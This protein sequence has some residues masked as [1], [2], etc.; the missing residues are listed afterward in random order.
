[1]NQPWILDIPD[2][3]NPDNFSDKD[4]MLAFRVLQ[5]K[6]ADIEQKKKHLFEKYGVTLQEENAASVRLNIFIQ[7][8]LGV[9]STERLEFESK[10]LDI[11]LGSLEHAHNQVEQKKRE[12]RANAVAPKIHLPDGKLHVVKPEN[13]NGS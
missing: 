11:V 2:E 1:M 13:K 12:D 8:M 6:C 7:N 9:D 4:Y 5:G 3:P 10:W